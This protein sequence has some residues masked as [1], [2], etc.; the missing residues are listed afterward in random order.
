MNRLKIHKYLPSPLILLAFL[1]SFIA[2]YAFASPILKDADIGWHILSGD[3]IREIGAVPMHDSWSFSGS[4]QTWYNIS[5]LWDVIIS[6]VHEKFGVQGLFVFTVACP[7]LLVALLLASLRERIELGINAL[8]LVGMISTYCMLEFATGR[9]QT[10]GMFFALFFHHIL[11]SS[12]KNINSRMVFLLPFL[13]ILW[14]NTHGSFLAGF[15]IIG[16]FGLEAIYSKNRAWVQKLLLIGILCIVAALVN[17]YGIHIIT[18]VTCTL[19]G[20]VE[21]YLVE[22]HPFM[23]GKEKGSSL[24]L[25]IFLLF[26]NFRGSKATI[27][28]KILVVVWLLA[29]FFSVRNLAMLVVLGAPYIAANL[30]IYNQKYSKNS[31]S[32]AWLND[33]RFSPIIMAV[34]PLLIICGYYLLPVLGT[35]HYLDKAR[36]SPLPAINYVVQNYSGKRVLNDY[37]YGG[38]IIYETKGKLPIFT[39][40]RAGTVYSKKILSDFLAFINLSDGWQKTIEPYNVD[41]IMLGT[42]RDFVKDYKRGL[43]HDMWEKTFSDEVASVYVRKN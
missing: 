11:H 25:L 17:P 9:P 20:V 19:N 3:L 15:I 39:D 7:A 31:K 12:R 4:T 37:D 40:G 6:F 38:R 16:A 30:V 34:V 33:S 18:A 42:G 21:K 24:W 2:L 28:D 13:M 5:W 1:V 43:Y 41:V 22:W 8:I 14:V 29:M 27:A 32:L 36:S 10:I 23:F 35:E 26:G